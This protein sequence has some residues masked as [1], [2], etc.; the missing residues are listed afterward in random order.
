MNADRNLTVVGLV[1]EGQQMSKHGVYPRRW[2]YRIELEK[3]RTR[4]VGCSG[5]AASR[6]E[7]GHLNSNLKV[8]RRCS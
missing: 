3:V 5:Q 8:V 7:R 4:E 2:S 1:R 6:P